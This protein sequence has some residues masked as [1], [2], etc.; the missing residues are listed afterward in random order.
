MVLPELVRRSSTIGLLRLYAEILT[1]LLRRGV[2]RSRNAPA[3]DLAEHLAAI[4][5]QGK[6]APRSAKSW[7]LRTADDRRLQVKGRVITPGAAGNYSVFR[8]WDFDLCVFVQFDPATY[9]ITA[10][11]EV[12]MKAVRSTARATPHV[13]GHRI[14]LRDDLL[15]L[16]GAVDRTVEFRQVLEGLDGDP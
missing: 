15:A 14:L 8:S 4:V 12:P 2:V 7:D 3:G 13:N 1:E 9:N 11:V 6:L 5:Y 16:D 10:A